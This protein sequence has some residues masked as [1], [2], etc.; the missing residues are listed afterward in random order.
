MKINLNINEVNM[1]LTS[2]GKMPYEYVYALIENI[3][4]QASDKISGE[5]LGDPSS[6]EK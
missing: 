2:L 4:K 6:S 3:R 5:S 1:V